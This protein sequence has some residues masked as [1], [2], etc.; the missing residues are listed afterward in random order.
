M[1]ESFS[2]GARD[3][4]G[5]NF[6][7]LTLKKRGFYRAAPEKRDKRNPPIYP[8]LVRMT[9]HHSG[10]CALLS[11]LAR[12]PIHIHCGAALGH[13][14]SELLGAPRHK[15]LWLTHSPLQ[16]APSG[17]KKKKKKKKDR[18]KEKETTFLHPTPLPNFPNQ[19]TPKGT[20]GRKWKGAR[21]RFLWVWKEEL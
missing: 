20:E 3:S 18:Q 8:G 4:I 2:P 9:C 7:N 15:T 13:L 6:N 17:L 16:L 14:C 19:R 10:R 1:S 12:I 5:E 21:W 11:H